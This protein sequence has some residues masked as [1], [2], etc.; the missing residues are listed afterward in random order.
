MAK[1]MTPPLPTRRLLTRG[2]AAGY[3]GVSVDTL[4]AHAPLA[5]PEDTVMEYLHAHEEITNSID[6]ISRE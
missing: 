2:E 4:Q 3:C 5:S 6:A 1:S